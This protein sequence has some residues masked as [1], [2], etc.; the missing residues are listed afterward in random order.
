[1]L[2]SV[3]LALAEWARDVLIVVCLVGLFVVFVRGS[4]KGTARGY[5][6]SASPH[7]SAPRRGKVANDSETFYD[8]HPTTRSADWIVFRPV[9][10]SA[11][12]HR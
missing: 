5:A 1:M 8:D 7:D 9:L 12:P 2:I 6:G 11:A 4:E 3:V 10:T